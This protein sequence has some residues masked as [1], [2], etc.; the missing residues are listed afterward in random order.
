[1][2]KQVQET[3]M[4]QHLISNLGNEYDD[5]KKRFKTGK[6]VD[7]FEEL[8]KIKGLESD[9]LKAFVLVL[10]KKTKRALDYLQKIDVEN[11]NFIEKDVYYELLEIKPILKRYMKKLVS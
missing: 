7:A 9:L 5:F 2:K 10:L 6:L 4:F 3:G 1:M 11:Q 8:E